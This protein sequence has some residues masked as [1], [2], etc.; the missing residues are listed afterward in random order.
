VL[1]T[2][3]GVA[4]IFSDSSGVIF[5]LGIAPCRGD[6]PLFAGAGAR[7]GSWEAFTTCVKVAGATRR[8]RRVDALAPIENTVI[9]SL[10]MPILASQ[11]RGIGERMTTRSHHP[12]AEK[13][14]A[15]GES[16]PRRVFTGALEEDDAA[17]G[18]GMAKRFAH[19]VGLGIEKDGTYCGE[20]VPAP[21]RNSQEAKK[22]GVEVPDEDECECWGIRKLLSWRV[23]P[24]HPRL[25]LAGSKGSG[26][27]GQDGHDAF[28]VVR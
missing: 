8:H 28:Q 27:P 13:A 5:A 18:E 4:S 20:P 1:R 3:S 21:A 25:S 16:T 6:H 10:S 7:Y 12:R 2:A 9:R 14:K 22:H 11:H 15:L 23:K 26:G 19:G 24:G 17:R